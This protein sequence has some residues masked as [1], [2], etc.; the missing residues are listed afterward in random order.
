MKYNPWK[1]LKRLSPH[2]NLDKVDDRLLKFRGV[3]E[4]VIKRGLIPDNSKLNIVATFV[5]KD[6]GDDLDLDEY[7][8]QCLDHKLE[9]KLVE[10]KEGFLNRFKFIRC[11]CTVLNI[12]V[13]GESI[14]SPWGT[15]QA[16]RFMLAEK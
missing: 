5:Q 6:I 12:L 3:Q 4:K 2:V 1:Y 14:I 15:F 9:L 8:S 13:D 16:P 10:Y 7:Q 11:R